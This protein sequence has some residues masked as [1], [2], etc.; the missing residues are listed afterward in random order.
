MCRAM[1]EIAE[2]RNC[3]T[4]FRVTLEREIDISK[5]VDCVQLTAVASAS[6]I[7][8]GV[9]FCMKGGVYIAQ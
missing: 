3:A 2:L 6:G 1:S 4:D 9:K 7:A 8:P 5:K